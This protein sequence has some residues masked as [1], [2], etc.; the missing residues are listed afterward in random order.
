MTV[1]R[2]LFN[3]VKI[4]IYRLKNLFKVAAGNID[5]AVEA[6]NIISKEEA[7]KIALEKVN[8][9]I[10]KFELDDISNDDGPEYEIKV[11]TKECSV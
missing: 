4:I 10:I 9:E 6:N 1:K 8:G 11:K 2:S 5:K 3:I 7:K